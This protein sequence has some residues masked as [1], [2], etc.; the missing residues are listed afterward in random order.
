MVINMK[1]SKIEIEH[2]KRLIG[3][4][5]SRGINPGAPDW[6]HSAIRSVEE[7]DILMRL[8]DKLSKEEDDDEQR[9][10]SV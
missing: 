9:E 4:A 3:F 1:F 2:M 8:F 5:V 7:C 10:V 6:D